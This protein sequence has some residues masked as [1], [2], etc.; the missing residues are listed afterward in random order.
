MPNLPKSIRIREAREADASRVADLLRQLGYPT[1]QEQVAD[2]LRRLGVPDTANDGV[3]V[4]CLEDRPVAW[5]QVSIV[6]SLESGPFAEIRGLVVDENHRGARI[7]EAL[8]RAAEAWAREHGQ[9]RLRVRSNVIRERAHRF[10]LRLGYEQ[11][12][13]QAVFV[14]DLG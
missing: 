8:V 10:Y 9:T 12:K 4:A 3:L 6:D 11:A 7:G 5:I 14:R 1:P 2:R 13:T